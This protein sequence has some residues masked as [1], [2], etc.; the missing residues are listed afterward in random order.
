MS[1]EKF[2][3]KNRVKALRFIE[4]LT[5][6]ELAEKSGIAMSSIWLLENESPMS[7]VGTMRAISKALDRKVEEVFDINDT[8]TEEDQKLIVRR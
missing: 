8:W 7:Q 3:M 6:G 4:N 2:E 1:K 5:Q